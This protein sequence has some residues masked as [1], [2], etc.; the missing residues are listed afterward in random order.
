MQKN[1]STG[2]WIPNFLFEI[3]DLNLNDIL[4]YSM[5]ESLGGGESGC[6]ASNSY[7]GKR[8][9]KNNDTVRRSITK[10][11][12]NDY[13]TY[14]KDFNYKSNRVLRVT[15]KATTYLKT[16]EGLLKNDRVPLVKISNNNKTNNININS[17]STTKE[18]LESNLDLICGLCKKYNK[19]KEVESKK[20]WDND[21][22]LYNHF[23]STL[24]IKIKEENKKPKGKPNQEN[25]MSKEK[26]EES[27]K[28]F[29]DRFNEISGNEYRITNSLRVCFKKQLENGFSGK[30]MLIAAD[31][32]YSRDLKNSWHID[33][34]YQVATP[35]FLLS[36]DNLNKYLNVNWLGKLDFKTKKPNRL[37]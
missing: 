11:F 28:W 32:M 31:K 20:V 14:E 12:D 23:K 18:K 24:A 19:E 15:N 35:E 26:F 8:L 22:D 1:G 34:G 4:I 10:L 25:Q 37:N 21:S 33:A 5:I 36:K 2:V 27:I 3:K 16:P 6:F 13:I 7:F 9:K 17:S 29:V 30:E